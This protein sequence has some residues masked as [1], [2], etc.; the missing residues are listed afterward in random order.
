MV[1]KATPVPVIEE[2][3]QCDVY[4]AVHTFGDDG[5][6]ILG[7]FTNEKAANKCAVT[8]KKEDGYKGKAAKGHSYTAE[9]WSVR[10]KFEG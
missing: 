10:D 6:E 9:P 4:I 1:K 5:Q 2:G 7:V 8:A 3:C